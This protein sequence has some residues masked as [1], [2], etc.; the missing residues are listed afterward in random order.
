M[1]RKRLLSPEYFTHDGLFET[2]QETQL[3]VRLSFAGL[4]T[5]ADRNG[6]F[7]WKPLQLKLAILPFDLVDFALVLEA[8]LN[9]GF[10]ERYEVNGKPYGRIP[11]FERWQTFHMREK[12]SY[13][14]PDATAAPVQHSAST[15][16]AR[17]KHKSDTSTARVK[18][19]AGPTG[20]VTGTVA[21]TRS[22][23]RNSTVAAR[24]AQEKPAATATT[25][26]GPV[27]APVQHETSTVP[28]RVQHS[29]S[30]V[31]DQREIED[32]ANRERAAEKLAIKL[33]VHAN[34]G[35]A[36]RYGE[37]PTVL[38]GSSSGAKRLADAILEQRIDADFACKEIRTLAATLTNDKPPVSVWY[39][40][41][42]LVDRWH[43][44]QARRQNTDSVL[45]TD[46][47]MPEMQVTVSYAQ[48]MARD[49]S[50]E[51]QA[52]CD[53]HGID[54]QATANV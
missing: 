1:A 30:T 28:A 42:A 53:Q 3:P 48:Q 13:P 5:Q 34:A 41:N 52:L 20:T 14:L 7:A 37:L 10:I 32:A 16:P 50:E 4:W 19:S 45:V 31:P 35:I 21:V 26:Q 40:H 54:W 18:H 11:T 47:L 43:D 12:A 29:A 9:A 2:E 49:G 23:E 25:A 39:F 8:L 33:A 22:G 17:G 27:P 6:V 46:A 36:E 51:W 24:K 44:L 15:V 38:R